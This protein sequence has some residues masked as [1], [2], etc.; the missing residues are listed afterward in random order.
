MYKKK[1]IKILNNGVELTIFLML[2]IPVELVSIVSKHLSLAIRLFINL[3]AGHAL[4]KVVS[5]FGFVIDINP[6]K[7]LVE[8][9]LIILELIFLI[10]LETGV[11]FIQAYV[12]LKLALSFSN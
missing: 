7:L 10:T 12:F 5:N 1:Y 6:K 11:S 8:I 4:L 9:I 3:M 2:L